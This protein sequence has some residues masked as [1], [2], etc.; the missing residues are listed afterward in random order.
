[1][2]ASIQTTGKSVFAPSRSSR[3]KTE[4]MR[5]AASVRAPS[6]TSHADAERSLR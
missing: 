1:M 3:M 4:C 6:H 2:E 5:E